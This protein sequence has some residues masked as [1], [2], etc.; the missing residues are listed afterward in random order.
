MTQ[1]QELPVRKFRVI[2]GKHIQNGK[3]YVAGKVV[4]S[5]HDLAK[6]F[7]GKFAEVGGSREQTASEAAT[8]AKAKA[9]GQHP[10]RPED[11]RRQGQNPTSTNPRRPA[12]DAED[13]DAEEAPV[14]PTSRRQ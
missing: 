12:P 3:E 10:T 7:V 9:V 4:K 6:Q 1:E 5:T 2:A 13:D 14:R 8:T 11:P